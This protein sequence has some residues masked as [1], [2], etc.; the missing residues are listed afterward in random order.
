MGRRV[1]EEPDSPTSLPA[2][3]G[4][5]ASSLHPSVQW[6]VTP[7]G[8]RLPTQR[9][10]SEQQPWYPRSA[11]AQPHTHLTVPPRHCPAPA[12]TCPHQLQPPP[13][14]PHPPRTCSDLTPSTPNRRH[15][16][17]PTSNCPTSAPTASSPVPIFPHPPCVSHL[18]PHLLTPVCPSPVHSW[19]KPPAF[20]PTPHL[21]FALNWGL[22]SAAGGAPWLLCPLRET[23][24]GKAASPPGASG[25]ASPFHLQS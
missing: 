12:H 3:A 21:G 18:S 9:A 10:G 24:Q 7:D 6:A 11:S 8:A 4:V 13:R 23:S 19:S 14:A 25:P 15:P 22:F 2:P 5:W 17:P 20:T 1:W 16:P